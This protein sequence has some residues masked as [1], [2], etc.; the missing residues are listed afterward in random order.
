MY[1]FWK[2]RPGNINLVSVRVFNFV[3]SERQADVAG[4]ARTCRC[5]RLGLRP[6]PSAPGDL[7]Q[8]P[9]LPCE[10]QTASALEVCWEGSRREQVRYVCSCWPLLGSA[11]PGCRCPA[12]RR[13]KTL[14]LGG[15]QSQG[16]SLLFVF[17]LLYVHIESE[18]VKQNGEESMLWSQTGASGTLFTLSS[19]Q[20]P[21]L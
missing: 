10:M 5:G 19:S 9:E 14:L 17:P 13:L 6:S 1:P 15:G 11:S 8:V 20:F 3:R 4:K 18:A 21:G 7:E 16:R 2:R 12:V